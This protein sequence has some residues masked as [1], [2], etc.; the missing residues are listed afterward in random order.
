MEGLIEEEYHKE[1]LQLMNRYN[2]SM[3][4]AKVLHANSLSSEYIESILFDELK[5]SS[6]N[7]KSVQQVVSR[8]QLAKEKNEKVLVCGDYDADGI[9]A[10]TIMY[11][12]LKRY[13]IEVGYYIPN[14]LQ[15]GYGLS[16]NTVQAA[17]KKN[18]QIIITVDNGVKANDAIELAKNLNIECIITDHHAY[19]EAIVCDIF[20]H[21]KEMQKT[22]QYLCGAGVAYQISLA[23]G[24]NVA[25]HVILAC[26]ATIADMV[27]LWEENRRI[28]KKGLEYL[29]KGYYPAIQFLRNDKGSIWDEKII[30]FQIIPKINSTGRLADLANANNTVRYLLQDNY[31]VLKDF[32]KQM[33]QLNNKRRQMSLKMVDHAQTLIEEKVNFQVLHDENFHEGLIGLVASKIVDLYK[34]PTMVFA[35]HNDILKGSIRSYGHI[36]L[37]NFFD[38]CTIP[39]IS[40]GGHERAAGISINKEYLADLKKYLY[41]KTKNYTYLE[42]KSNDLLLHLSLDEITIDSVTEY[43]SLAPFGEGLRKPQFYI[44]NLEVLNT[45]LLSNNKHIK[46]C[47]EQDIDVLM[48][49][50]D[51]SMKSK[52]DEKFISCV[53]DIHINE[54]RG[55]KKIT[56]F[57]TEIL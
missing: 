18:Y 12:A 23:L 20:V 30:S 48:F 15:E 35:E 32:S 43:L 34:V 17:Y 21:P 45:Q 2:I 25:E 40:Y 10:T 49:S 7:I 46:W 29:N 51:E 38:D 16:T 57:A 6:V 41:D 24:L 52:C 11:D 28:V 19:D 3:L 54:F 26:I 22:Y 31:H 53:G 4:T 55:T 42:N 13:G 50:V 56:I 47:C 9:C 37:R 39:F 5:N 14:R 1:I 44:S 36:D 8:I 33:S 27:P